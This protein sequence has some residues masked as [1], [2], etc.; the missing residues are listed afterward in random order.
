M[1][2]QPDTPVWSVHHGDALHV[3]AG[4]ADEQFDAVITD[5]PYCSG[6]RSAAERTGQRT[7]EKYTSSDAQHT[8]PDFAGDTRDQRSYL[9]WMSLVL[10]QCYRLTRKGGP[11][12]LFSDWRQFPVTSDALQAAGWIWRGVAVWTN[13]TSRPNRCL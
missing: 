2:P 5:R 3:L 7:R 4:M 6:G 13:T 11:L 8:L 10:G 1:T 9:A 12:L